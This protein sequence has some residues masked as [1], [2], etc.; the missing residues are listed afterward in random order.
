ME[1]WMSDSAVCALRFRGALL[2]SV[3]NH[4]RHSSITVL[5]SCVCKMIAA[6]ACFAWTTCA[7][8]W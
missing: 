8:F 6:S 7:L 4:R 3:G 2:Y 5:T 1:S